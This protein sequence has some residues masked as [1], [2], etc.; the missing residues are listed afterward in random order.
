MGKSIGNLVLI[1]VFAAAIVV[2]GVRELH[3][4]HKPQDLD[5]DQSEEM[6]MLIKLTSSQILDN[7]SSSF[8]FF[9]LSEMKS[10]TS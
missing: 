9:S 3:Q 10:T 7:L 8:F 5:S 4:M 1:S 2:L 6:K